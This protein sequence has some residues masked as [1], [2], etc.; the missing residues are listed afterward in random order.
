VIFERDGDAYVPTGHARGPWD[1]D[2]LHGGGPCALLAGAI[3]RLAPE[4]Q[5]ARLTVEF[6]GA[7]PLAPVEV[8]A[9]I[10]RRGR[11]FQLAEATLRAEGRDTLRARAS[12]L[13]VGALPGVP[14]GAPVA[15]L[16]LGPRDGRPI[17]FPVEGEAEGFHRTGMEIR[18]TGGSFGASGPATAWFRLAGELVAGEPTS[19]VQRAVAAADFGNGVSHELDW[20][21]W[22]FINTDLDVHLHRPPCGEWVAL[23]AR[24]VLEPRGVGL[25]VSQLHDEKGAIGLAQQTLFV[26]P[27]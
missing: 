6:L 25:A 19:A 2:Q 27:R 9:E 7:V 10:V 24:T 21:D 3:E 13:R 20:N 15:P 11:R 23:D 16:T 26:D 14:R 8:E 12:L 4:M 22:L 18:F 5:L 1:P 17:A